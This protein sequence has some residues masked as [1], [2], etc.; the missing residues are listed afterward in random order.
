MLVFLLDGGGLAEVDFYDLAHDGFAVKDL[1]DTDGGVIVE[2]GD[3]YAAEGLEG[4]P[5]VNGC[6]GVDEFADCLEVVGPED[7]FVL[8]VGDD[9]CV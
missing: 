2:E 3:D 8:E 1:L 7:F 6:G 4:C 9:E 5:G